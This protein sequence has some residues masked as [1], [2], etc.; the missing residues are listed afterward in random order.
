MNTQTPPLKDLSALLALLDTET[1]TLAVF[2]ELLKREHD[3]LRNNHTDALTG[4]VQEKSRLAEQLNTL[5]LQRSQL[6]AQQQLTS[7]RN[8]MERLRHQHAH[9]PSG[10][11]L[12]A[13]WQR[14]LALA[15]EA[16][17]L[18]TSNGLLIG[19]RLTY[20]QQ[21]LHA[22]HAATDQATLYGPDG[23]TQATSSGRHIGSA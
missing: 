13:L 4:L 18:N 23:Q 5:S 2:S 16:Q 3:A 21:L 6:L 1:Q 20:N 12:D 22:L 9:T 7:D 17:Q 19:T 11:R 10:Q 15:T 14:W 8:G